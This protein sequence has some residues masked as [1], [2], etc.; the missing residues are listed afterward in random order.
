MCGDTVSSC[1]NTKIHHKDCGE[2]E[3]ERE[4]SEGEKERLIEFVCD[5]KRQKPRAESLA[6]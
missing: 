2:R 1:G 4:D 6:Q 3:R 5:I